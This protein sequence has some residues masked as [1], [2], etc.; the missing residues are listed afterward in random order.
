MNTCPASCLPE[1]QRQKQGGAVAV[2]FE[3]AYLRALD[4]APAG[5]HAAA[6]C[7]SPNW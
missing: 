7:T 6:A 4:F 5:E 3:A 2:K 1:L